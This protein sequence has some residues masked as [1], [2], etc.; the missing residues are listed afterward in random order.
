MEGV[1]IVSPSDNLQA[2]PVESGRAG[3]LREL[4][5]TVVLTLIIFLLIRSVV[6]NFRIDGVSMEP[7][8]HD[9][10]FL[11]INKLAYKI[12]RPSR[13][14]VIVFRYPHDPHRDFIKRVIGLPGDVVML[15]DGELFINGVRVQEPYP[16]LKGPPAS[17]QKGG[18]GSE[19]AH[20]YEVKPGELFVLGDNR[21]NSSDSR[22]W[23]MVPMNLVIGKAWISY[24]PPQYWSIVP[25]YSLEVN[26]SR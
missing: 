19:D 25:H 3:A 24:W 2:Q 17:D 21:Q 20:V 23:G 18:K 4:I 12:G 5:E 13:G 15:R 11:I 7:N 1:S 22:F 26:P 16:L 8:F 10:Q 9:G 14:D 6:Q